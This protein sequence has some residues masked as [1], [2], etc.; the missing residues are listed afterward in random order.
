MDD[1]TQ[2]AAMVLAGLCSNPRLTEPAVVLE[3]LEVGVALNTIERL[4][5]IS[6]LFAD[7]V[8]EKAHAEVEKRRLDRL[9]DDARDEARLNAAERK[10]AVAPDPPRH[11]LPLMVSGLGSGMVAGSVCRIPAPPAARP[12]RRGG[13]GPTKPTV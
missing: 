9:A 1:R 6:F 7:D 11:C 2:I 8:L 3:T 10:A 5:R 12:R 13:Q 4:T